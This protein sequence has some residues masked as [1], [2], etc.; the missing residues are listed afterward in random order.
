MSADT[1]IEWAD[2]TFNPWHGCTQI[3]PG[4]TWAAPAA[5]PAVLAA[6]EPPAVPSSSRSA[7]PPPAVTSSWSTF[8]NDAPPLLSASSPARPA[9]SSSSTSSSSA[10][11]SS[12]SAAAREAEAADVV[13]MHARAALGSA[14]SEALGLTQ[15]H[16]RRWPRR[17]ALEREV[18]AL[19]RLGRREEATQRARAV[20][21]RAQGYR[22]AL[23]AAVGPLP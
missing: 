2:D 23:E 11:A 18:R 4:C 7:P 16:A 6:V 1:S 20:V 10:P 12:S 17:N 21:E 8:T 15:E 9:T 5:A 19:A 14:P 13:L 3:S 22:G